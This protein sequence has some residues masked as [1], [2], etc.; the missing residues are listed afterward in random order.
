[1]DII[2]NWAKSTLRQ[3]SALP[4]EEKLRAAMS[5]LLDGY[6]EAIRKNAEYEQTIAV[7]KAT[8]QRLAA[9]ADSANKLLDTCFG[10][11]L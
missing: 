9:E 7:Q 4:E 1:M 3:L 8:I 10:G 2:T 5:I 11:M 6:T